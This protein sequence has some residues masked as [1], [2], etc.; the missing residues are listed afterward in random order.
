M[1][2]GHKCIKITGIVPAI[3]L[4]IVI[5][6]CSSDESA[7]DI[8]RRSI[9][10]VDTVE[11]ISYKQDMSRSNPR[12]IDDTIFRYREM[13][14][15]RLIRD[16]IVGVKG[17]WYFYNE[18]KTKVNYEDIYDGNKLIRKNNLD[19]SAILYDLI[20]YP[21]FKNEHFWSHNTPYAL[22]YT[23]KHMLINQ[24]TYVIERINDTSFMN[25]SCF[26][27]SIHL[28][29]MMTMPGFAIKLEVM[30]G[31]IIKTIFIIEKA[32]YYPLRMMEE[33]YSSAN[34]GQKV[35]IDQT[36]Y[37]IKFNPDLDED[38]LFNTS[39]DKLGGFEIEERKPH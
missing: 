20:K 5:N 37:D 24:D 38:I 18:D 11:T 25:K 21:E 4:M 1:S 32:T 9:A 28:E 17:H 39:L 23:F 7:H 22:Q 29:D 6:S 13:Y 14:F 36:Y 15:K 35:F 2:Y 30:E 16:S 27:I 31:S 12:Q 10:S 8:L 34:T 33:Y 26:Q 3:M 19:S